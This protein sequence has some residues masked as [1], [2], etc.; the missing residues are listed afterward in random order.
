MRFVLLFIALLTRS[1]WVMA[2]DILPELASTRTN[3]SPKIDGNISDSCWKN[4]PIA[5]NFTVSEPVYGAK[6]AAATEVKIL[7]DNRAIYVCAK[8]YD[9]HP[10]SISHE[11]GKRDDNVNADFFSVTFDTYNNRQDAFVFGV[12]ASGVQKDYKIEIQKI[13]ENGLP[14]QRFTCKQKNGEEKYPLSRICTIHKTFPGIRL[15]LIL[16]FQVPA[17]GFGRGN[18]GWIFP[19]QCPDEGRYHTIHIE[20]FI[21]NQSR[22]Q[23]RI[24]L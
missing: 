9:L 10:D 15:K 4:L 11:L 16:P 8:L 20:I 14:V 19:E 21:Y 18:L 24:V 7:Y 1:F 2:Q 5:S 12:Y 23:E 22:C 6:P 13:G 3:Q 17:S